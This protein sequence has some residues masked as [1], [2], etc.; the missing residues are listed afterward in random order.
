MTV[1]EDSKAAAA[2]SVRC[3]DAADAL[4]TRLAASV[5]A[6]AKVCAWV[7]GW[8]APHHTET[9]LTDTATLCNVACG[10]RSDVAGSGRCGWLHGTLC[11]PLPARTTGLGAPSTRRLG[12]P[13]C[14]PQPLCTEQPGG[15]GSRHA[16]RLT[17][18][19][20][21][22]AYTAPTSPSLASYGVAD[23]G[24]GADARPS[25]CVGAGCHRRRR[26]VGHRSHER[27]STQQQC[28]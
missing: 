19:C 10:T 16:R 1:A 20:L 28:M 7:R 12:L 22:L 15:A 24:V 3:F 9:Q 6:A 5:T 23:H 17:P 18:H 8:C 26:I 27:V 13:T 21:V 2:A 11:P 25:A 4:T 14:V